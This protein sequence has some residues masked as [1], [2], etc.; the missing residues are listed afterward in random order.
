MIRL[1]HES[2][3]EGMNQQDVYLVIVAIAIVALDIFVRLYYAHDRRDAFYRSLLQMQSGLSSRTPISV[4]APE[5]ADDS[6]SH[7]LLA[8]FKQSFTSRQVMTALATSVDGMPGR[9]LEKQIA[10]TVAE[11]WNRELSIN[12]IR[13]VIMILMGAN[14][15]NLHDGKFAL[16]NVGWNLFLKTKRPDGPRWSEA[17]S[18]SLLPAQ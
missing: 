12:A 5:N 15:V 4:T 3:K 7:A 1:A 16:T 10:E 11:K 6:L 2:L 17:R 8:Y 13:R 9:Q 18:R 14:L